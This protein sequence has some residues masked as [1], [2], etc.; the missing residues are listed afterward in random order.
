MLVD[1]GGLISRTVRLDPAPV[2]TMRDSFSPWLGRKFQGSP[3]FCCFDSIQYYVG[4]VP[5]P[6]WVND[7]LRSG[8][9]KRVSLRVNRPEININSVVEN[10]GLVELELM[11]TCFDK[12]VL[13]GIDQLSS[14]ELLSIYSGFDV[15]F[16]KVLPHGLPGSLTTLHMNSCKLE[17]SDLKALQNCRRLEELTLQRGSFSLRALAETGLPKTLKKADFYSARLVKADLEMLAACPLL[18]ELSLGANLLDLRNMEESSPLTSVE[19]L[20]LRG[21]TLDASSFGWLSRLPKLKNLD[22]RNC[23]FNDQ[24]AKGIVLSPTFVGLTCHVTDP[25]SYVSIM[26]RETLKQAREKR[27]READ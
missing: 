8:E 15:S 16:E 9:L 21:A 10:S 1:G 13:E 19:S 6:L 5:M 27:N 18:T 26:V 14:L 23:K 20:D 12:H 25:T 3:V 17:T 11:G 7:V 2:V 4:N 24:D 22:L